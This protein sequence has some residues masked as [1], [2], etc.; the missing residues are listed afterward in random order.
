M[1]TIARA[2]QLAALAYV[3]P[4]DHVG[5]SFIAETRFFTD[6]VTDAQA[7]LFI[8]TADLMVVA[9]RGTNSFVDVLHDLDTCPAPYKNEARYE[10]AVVHGGLLKQHLAV[11][12]LIGPLI[13]KFLHENERG[14]VCYVGHSAGGALAAFGALDTSSTFPHRVRYIGFGCP[15]F[16]ND[17]FRK[18]FHAHVDE[19]VMVKNGR[20]PITKVPPVYVNVCNLQCYGPLDPYPDFPCLLDMREHDIKEYVRAV[21]GD[22]M[23]RTK[24]WWERIVC[25]IIQF[26]LDRL[27]Q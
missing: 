4:A 13:H 5:Q 21:S 11:H 15:R 18:V 8:E 20:D 16:S 2:A 25:A 9:I 19:A 17:A 7:Y 23:A 14:H 26:T 6:C 3:P 22:A 27:R 12:A 10:G 24:N 1:I